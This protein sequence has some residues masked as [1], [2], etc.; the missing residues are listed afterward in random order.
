[1]V[2]RI[3][4]ILLASVCFA[5]HQQDD[6]D[7]NISQKKEAV[8]LLKN[9]VAVQRDEIDYL[10]AE[11]DSRQITKKASPKK[12]RYE[13]F[14]WRP[15]T[16]EAAFFAS[17]AFLYWRTLLAP[18]DYAIKD[19]MRLANTGATGDYLSTEY[20]WDPGLRLNMGYRFKPYFWEVDATY[21][22]FHNSGSNN[23]TGAPDP[24]RII[25]VGTFV[26]DTGAVLAQANSSLDID[27]HLL[28]I[29]LSRRVLLDQNLIFK[30]FTGMTAAWI[31][32]HFKVKYFS[33]V[34]NQEFD[35]SFD[36]DGWGVKTGA[37][38]DW[39]IGKG[40]S[41]FGQIAFAGL[42]GSYENRQFSKIF[43]PDGEQ[44]LK[45]NG[46]TDETWFAFN[47]QFLLGP[48]WGIQREKWGLSLV[49]AYEINPWFNLY[50]VNRSDDSPAEDG[51]ASNNTK[52]LLCPQGLTL[53]LTLTF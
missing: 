32:Q 27:F 11:L 34:N 45:L 40:L 10:T 12:A 51:K 19:Q 37:S 29:L 36:Y 13:I 41:L 25:L 18:T 3:L 23:H 52:G 49:A 44:T 48:R 47:T 46:K 14:K 30:F 16:H 5:S 39:Y 15:D 7:T 6:P 50:Q 9:I 42:A 21:T 1:M 22:Y 26:Q 8:T 43:Q 24:N 38:T 28:D 31:D 33:L 20:D 17:G 4:P 35:I 2:K 53:N